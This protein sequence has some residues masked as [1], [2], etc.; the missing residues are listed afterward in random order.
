MKDG[1]EC[2]VPASFVLLAT[3]TYE[4]VRL[5]LLSSSKQY[6]H[7]LSN[8]HGQVGKHYSGALTRS[9]RQPAGAA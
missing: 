7:G 2:F 5:L 1:R 9:R 6:P 4:N 3:F 8:N